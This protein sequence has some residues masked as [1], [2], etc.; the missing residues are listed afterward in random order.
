MITP[1]K[2][3]DKNFGATSSSEEE[4]ED[5]VSEDSL[6]NSNE[7]DQKDTE[8]PVEDS[9]VRF[10]VFRC[11]DPEGEGER[12]GNKW[13]PAAVA[14]VSILFTL[15]SSAILVLR[16]CE[17]PRYLAEYNSLLK[18]ISPNLKGKVIFPN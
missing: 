7:E 12:S 5:C 8:G 2:I 15:S 1:T 3:I 6:M 4:N 16:P 9:S 17:L 10:V 13:N 18:I 14:A 11:S